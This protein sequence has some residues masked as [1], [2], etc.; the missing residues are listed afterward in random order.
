MSDTA[1][2]FWYGNSQAVE[3]PK[4]FHFG[5]DEVRIHKQGSSVILEPIVSNWQW[6]DEIAGKFSSDF[7]VAGRRQPPLPR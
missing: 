5:G 2:L 4:E 1:K 3:L 7:F 6:L